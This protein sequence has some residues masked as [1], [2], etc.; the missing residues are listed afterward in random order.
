MYPSSLKLP[1]PHFGNHISYSHRTAKLMTG[2]N[3]HTMT[4]ADDQPDYQ[5][6]NRYMTNIPHTLGKATLNRQS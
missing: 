6:Q 4:S 5:S 1:A 3:N 2:S